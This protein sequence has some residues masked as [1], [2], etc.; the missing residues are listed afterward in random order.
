M[1][2]AVSGVQFTRQAADAIVGYAA[3]ADDGLETGGILLGADEGL[4]APIVVRHCGGPGPTA[5][6]RRNF[7]RRDLAHATA[8]ATDAAASDGSAWIGE[9]HT[10]LTDMPEPS[11]CDLL[12][13]Q[14]LLDD[15]ELAFARILSVVV[16]AD[17]DHGWLTPTLHAWS[18]SGSV[19][20]RLSVEIAGASPEERDNP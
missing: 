7:F 8:L 6:R 9:W 11:G 16:L 3:A 2:C 5:D 19:L 17:P 12:T 13:Y 4:A 1:R 10:H 20:R 18:F 15:P 14:A